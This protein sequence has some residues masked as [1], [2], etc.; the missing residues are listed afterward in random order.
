MYNNLRMI[1]KVVVLLMLLGLVSLG[2]T[3]FATSRMRVINDSYSEIIAKPE[4]GVVA[5]A[6]ANRQV[7]SIIS[8]IYMKATA[9]TEADNAT[10][11]FD[12]TAAIAKYDTYLDA[13]VATLPEKAAEL[14]GIKAAL[15]AALEGACAV[16]IQHASSLDPAANAQAAASMNASCHPELKAVSARITK[17]VDDTV[18]HLDAVSDKTSKDTTEIIIVTYAAVLTG[19]ALV[20]GL[21][22]WLTRSGIVAPIRALTDTMQ[23]LT[24]GQFDT[25]VAG[26][27]RRDELGAMAVAVEVFRKG[28]I[29][30]EEMREATRSG[31]QAAAA[32]MKRELEVFNRFQER[33]G[34]LADA[35]VRSSAEVSDA[36]QS[37]ATTAEET[38]RQAGVVS[39]AAEEAAI[40]VQTVAAATEEMAMSVREINGQV[41]RTAEVAH[42]AASEAGR[43]EADIRILAE[44]AEGIGEVVNLINDIA[45]QTNLL[46]LN[47]TIEAARAGDA[48][49][50]F[51]VVASEVKALATQT[52]R[53]TKDIGNKVQQIQSATERTVVSIEKIVTTISDIRS[54]STI[55]ASAVEQQGTATQ[56][57]A[58]NTAQAADGAQAVTENIFG[59]GR[60]AEMTGAAST[61]LM[62]L[63]G[64][65][66][67]QAADL[68]QEVQAFVAQLRAS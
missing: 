22:I 8:S 31:E 33:M 4:K 62:G 64:H 42:E 28:L 56:E 23:S 19:L 15:H 67:D 3:V 47:A 55:L 10:A 18:L 46:A 21:A 12:R 41:G 25:Q 1:G 60:A 11:E 26:Q 63:S 16:T 59:V 6:R 58:G 37:L 51:A 36:A 65:L 54:I 14:T 9:V 44:A 35:F 49:K 45:A 34:A 43:T 32:R 66:T 39:G 38:S 50:G 52:A 29:E 27:N 57:I 40:N 20:L 48:G 24:H 13:A 30:A 17:M 7:V 61:Q 5:M 68:Q 2:A 53:A